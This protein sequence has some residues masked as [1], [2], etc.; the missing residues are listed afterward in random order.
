[1]TVL[2]RAH[3]KKFQLPTTVELISKNANSFWLVHTGTV[4]H[5]SEAEAARSSYFFGMES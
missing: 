5:T 2:A 4:K 1:M 3:I